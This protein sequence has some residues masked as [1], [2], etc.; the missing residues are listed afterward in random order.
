VAAVDVGAHNNFDVWAVHYKFDVG[1]DIVAPVDMVAVDIAGVDTGVAG[2]W[3][4]I[5]VEVDIGVDIDIGVEVDIE[6]VVFVRV[7]DNC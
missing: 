3:V 1:V 4:D 5:G 6:G 2:V 7:A